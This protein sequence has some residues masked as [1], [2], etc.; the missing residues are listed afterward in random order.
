MSEILLLDNPRRK[1]HRRTSRRKSKK[2]PASLIAYW[3]RKKKNAPTKAKSHRKRHTARKT[4]AGKRHRPVY[5]GTESTV[6]VRSP[7]KR[8]NPS[9]G[10]TMRHKK[11]SRRRRYRHNPPFSVK[12][13]AGN[14]TKGLKAALIG[15]GA[16]A[17]NKFVA[18]QIARLSGI[19][20]SN[21]QL[22]ELATALLVLPMAAKVVKMPALGAAANVAASSAI[23]D[24][25]KKYL[26][27]TVQAQLGDYNFPSNIPQQTVD[28]A[29]RVLSGTG[30]NYIVDP[31][32]SMIPGAAW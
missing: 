12:G 28:T 19:A 4:P 24:A 18:N 6:G 1:K 23:Y 17:A 10:N 26:P 22:V 14:A 16:I 7:F 20:T 27:A 2:M 31:G 25:A 11:H 21:K 9:K 15:A 29:G 8:L 5:Y 3:K 13:I 32:I 30:D